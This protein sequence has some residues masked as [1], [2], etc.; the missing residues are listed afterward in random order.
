MMKQSQLAQQDLLRNDDQLWKI[1]AKQ[2]LS[3]L[4]KIFE[5]ILSNLLL[6]ECLIVSL[7]WF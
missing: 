1:T 5:F 3:V 4:L 7:S 6:I 2:R